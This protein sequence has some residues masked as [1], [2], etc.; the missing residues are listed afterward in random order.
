MSISDEVRAVLKTAPG[1]LT[2][3]EIGEQI[4]ETGGDVSKILY[5][6]VQTGEVEKQEGEEGG[7]ATYLRN[8]K[9]VSKRASKVAPEIEE[10]VAGKKARKP[11]VRRAKAA[12]PK[13]TVRKAKPRTAAVSKRARSAGEAQRPSRPAES[14]G[15]DTAQRTVTLKQS[16]VRH[17]IRFAMSGD[18]QL[19]ADTRAAVIDATQE[20]A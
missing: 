14:S 6:F 2:A 10:P 17:L 18:R 15:V 9:H 11:Y 13:R 4:G 16:T 1:A 5:A 20:A 7:K 8:P 19:D 12:K 3:A